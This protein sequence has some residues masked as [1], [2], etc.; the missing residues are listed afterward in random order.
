MTQQTDEVA[1]QTPQAPRRGTEAAARP[2]L[3]GVY[4]LTPLQE[5]MLFHALYDTDGVD[6]Y[7]VQTAV[8]LT[9][10]LD[11]ARLESACRQV[12]RRHTVL[13]TAFQQR[14][15]GQPVQLVAREVA[16]PW[17]VTDLSALPAAEQRAR[18][19]R[20]LAEDRARRFDMSLP[21]LV[22]FA[23]VR[24][25]RDRHILVMTHHHI[26]LDGWSVPLVLGDLIELYARGGDDAAAAALRP[27][28]P[29]RDYLGWLA[30]QDRATAEDIWR[31]ALSGVE[32]P[33]L[34]AP[35]ADAAGGG[36]PRV[37]VTDLPEDVTARLTA[38]AR[39][40]GLTLN[41]VV[42]GA[43]ALL[44]G[45]LTGRQDVVFGG[46]VSGRPPQLSGVED[47]VGLLINAVPVRVRLDA[48]LPLA[49]L[50]TR[51][52]DEQTAL[53]P[54]HYLGLADVQRLAGTGELFDTSVAFEN[55]PASGDAAADAV[56]GLRIGLADLSHLGDEATGSNHYPL[57]LVATPGDR[58]RLHVNYRADIYE[59]AGAEDIAARLRHL[60]EVFADASGTPVG[61]IGWLTSGERELPARWNDT[62]HPVPNATLPELFEAQAA[63]SPD[64]TAAAFAAGAG[65]AGDA[66]QPGESLT[67]AEL[68]ARANRLARLLVERGVGPESKVAVAL[69]R[70]LDLVVTLL[71]VLKAGGAYLPFEPGLPAD[72]VAFM[73]EEAAPVAA[74][75]RGGLHLADTPGAVL[76]D[77]DATRVH[78][79]ALSAADLTSAERRVPLRPGHP[80]Y[81]LYTS[82]STGRP[83]GVAVPHEAITNR[84][85]WMQARYGLT[86]DDRVLQ[87]TPAGF[88]V[89]VWEFFW[90][91][92]TGAALVLARPDGH[93]DPVYL[94]ATIRGHA[95][96]TVHFV[97]SMLQAFTDEPTAAACTGLRRVIC[98]GEAL[99]VELA[100]RLRALLPDAGLHNLYGP[101]EA[102]VDVTHWAAVYEPGA[103]SVPIGR[104][105]WN[106]GIHVLDAE[107]RPVPASVPGELYIAGVQL[108][109]GYLNRPALTAERFV[110]DPF[111]PPGSRLYRTG[112]LARRRP[113]GVVEYL[114][115]SDHQVKIRGQR[116]ELGEIEAALDAQSG[117]AQSAVLA[118]E[119]RPGSLRLAAYVVAE[120]GH[121][122]DPEAL[123]TAVAAT[124]P[125]YMVPPDLLVLPAFPL[126]PNGKLD[127]GAL[128]RPEQPAP[129]AGREPRGERERTLCGLFADVLGLERVGADDS[130]FDLGGD[131][132][133]SIQLVARA[134]RTGLVLTPKDVFTHRSPAAL[135][136]VA[137]TEEGAVTESAD[138]GIGALP[139]T[140]IVHWLRERGGPSDAFHQS[141][142]LRVPADLAPD[143]L[144]RALQAVL[145]RH[146]ALRMRLS[147]RTTDGQWSLVVRRPG[148]VQ[149]AGLLSRQD[150]RGLDDAAL[151]DA[152]RERSAQA[153]A[154]LAPATGAMVRAV[155]FDAGAGR[156]GRLL[157]AVHHLAVDG[158]SWRILLPDLKAAWQ[159]AARGADPMPAPVPTSLRTWARRLSEAATDPRRTAELPLWQGVLAACD[160]PLSDAPLNPV[161][162]THATSSSL[163][164]RLPAEVT[165]SLLTTVPAAF[166]AG[167]DDI[168]L[169]ALALAVGAYRREQQ[170]G[171]DTGVLVDLESHGRED[172][173]PGLDTSRTVGWFT[174]LYPVRIDPAVTDWDEVRA[175]GPALGRAVKRVK[176]QLRAVPD[177]GVGYG[178][179]RHLNPE[180]GPELARYAPPQIGFNYLGRVS[181]S[182]EADWGLAAEQDAVVSGAQSTMPLWHTLDVNAVTEDR[183]DGPHLTATWTWA[184][185]LLSE[186]DVRAIAEAWCAALH[187]LVAHTC[188][189]GA[190]GLTPSDVLAEITQE[191]LEGLEERYAGSVPADV[192][193]L[194]PFQEGLLFH[195]RYY[196]GGVDVHNVQLVLELTGEL[197]RDLLRSVC[198]TLID[199]HPALRAGF[200]WTDSGRPVQVIQR[201]APVLWQEADLTSVGTEGPHAALNRLLNDD[202]RRRFDPEHSPL[203]RFTLVRMADDRH[204][205]LFTHHHILADG[206]SASVLLRDLAA[207]SA[208]PRGDAT[209][210]APAVSYRAYLRWL[211]EQ[212]PAAAQGAWNEA[213][214]GVTEP[215]LIAPHV[216]IAYVPELPERVLLEL[217]ADVTAAL[218]ATARG[219]GVTL[220]TLVQAVWGVLVGGL[221]GR[222]DVV[223]G[224]TVS[225]RPPELPG[226]EDMVGPLINT[227]PVRLRWDAKEPLAA[228]FARHQEEQTRLEGCR[229]LGLADIQRSAGVGCLFDTSVVFENYPSAQALPALPGTAARVTGFSGRDAYHYPLKLMAVP[230]ER[231]Y[232]ELS[233]RPDL[234]TPE[235]AETVAAQLLGL[236]EA[237]ANRPGTPVGEAVAA[238]G[239]L[240][241]AVAAEPRRGR[242]PAV[243]GDASRV[244]ETPVTPEEALLCDLFAEVLGTE[245][246]GPHDDFFDLGGDSLTALRLTGRVSVLTGQEL[247]VREVFTYPTAAELADHMAGTLLGRTA[248]Q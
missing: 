178:M 130:F 52:Q 131:S 231:L 239:R 233:H 27:A 54:Y 225:V 166:R 169:T 170:L 207:L 192:L 16:V 201:S 149:A 23:L 188:R 4:P 248:S 175:A 107:L 63:R 85:H 198:Q 244:R 226:V 222:S 153:A 11:P 137:R 161:R 102:A 111:G 115:R 243:P 24:M 96:T 206:W 3:E 44:L 180:T 199:R 53:T 146:D 144:T 237:A 154:E 156:P 213:L 179:L 42:Q 209:A 136:R 241:A 139:L 81:V 59:R 34:V 75:T 114:G 160:P 77:D 157:L 15:S 57:S 78:L 105:V 86:G 147:V 124:L 82:G 90:P 13:R 95:I 187:A 33:T 118:R 37:V 203:V 215:T 121:R 67:Y 211:A 19:R 1:Q 92:I 224:A 100:G 184:G 94:A 64:A 106:T 230:G 74:V 240:V 221:T 125:D 196:P 70:S 116:I 181:G 103:A 162:D 138:A 12:L 165:E 234:V 87:K 117:V 229:Y 25:A 132:I 17:Q 14:K 151:R 43:W 79:A 218:T 50:L 232:L 47:M 133:I 174:S 182:G 163:T 127:R 204:T 2:A 6:V 183:A 177:H 208:A 168:L 223:F 159:D 141:V 113:D 55:A 176:E 8:E 242:T 164:V 20:A 73:R 108:A 26:L 150:V 205:L 99:P 36:M 122:P 32:E 236:L 120:A 246:I 185:E 112:D 101:T 51:L 212:D 228:L 227:V 152:V 167:I 80:A 247:C 158:V 88:D 49:G 48:D 235:Q 56:A 217:P 189:P 140:P 29:F 89:S 202:R 220:N 41:T 134:R 39:S 69:P 128:P 93:R 186:V 46:T 40:H 71:A 123:R 7:N 60:L 5:G 190:G 91:L 84:L 173:V 97:P 31:R 155:W 197:D 214:D 194:S 68:N 148:A 143:A 61:R 126:T 18:L 195:A 238:I 245:A 66:G 38:T 129:A 219:Q 171:E 216:D 58:L 145:D 76:L 10:D 83:K 104:P 142:L 30:G 109:R 21:P 45:L 172:V 9:G 22:R 98:S 119:D 65:D 200:A 135:A 193:P 35:G 191:D 110:A 210:L 62:A 28:V 72:R